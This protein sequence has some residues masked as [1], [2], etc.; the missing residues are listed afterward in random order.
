M[1]AFLQYFRNP[2]MDDRNEKKPEGQAAV[3]IKDEAQMRQPAPSPAPPAPQQTPLAPAA[4]QGKPAPREFEPVK[5]LEPE[6]V[7]QEIIK[8]IEIK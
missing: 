2:F 1:T 8:E 7:R 4:M 5:P 6:P 3:T